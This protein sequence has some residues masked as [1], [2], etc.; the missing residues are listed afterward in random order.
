MDG[1]AP[2]IGG[3]RRCW[4]LP[5]GLLA[6]TTVYCVT[7]ALNLTPYVRGPREWRWVYA[8]PEP[9][10]WLWIPSVTLLFYIGLAKLWVRSSGS[11]KGKRPLKRRLLLGA[12]ILSV[13]LL[14]LSLLAGIYGDPLKPLF[15]RTVSVGASGVFSVG[16]TI[17]DAGEFLRRY[18]DLMPTFPV[19]PQRYPPGLPLLFYGLRRLFERLPGVANVVGFWLRPYQ[20]HDLVLMRLPNTTL[21]TAL[22]Q[23]A[24]PFF[25]GLTLLPLYAFARQVMGERTAVFVA[26]LY[27]LVPS[28]ALWSARWEQFYPLLTVLVGYAFY[29][30][31]VKPSRSVMFL[32][33]LLLA[34]SSFLNF[35][36]LT[37][38]ILCGL[39]ALTYA[40][41]C[42]ERQLRRHM[43]LDAMVFFLGLALPWI[44]YQ[45]IFGAGFFD[46]WRV[47]MSYHLGLERSYWTWV[48]FHLY[49]FFVFLGLPL[50]VLFLVGM[51]RAVR[52]LWG[53]FCQRGVV[54]TG[55]MM[56]VAVSGGILLLDLS[57]VSRGEV[58]RVWLFLTPL[59]AL[60]A[61]WGLATIPLG[62]SEWGLVFV[63]VLLA[64]QLSIGNAYLRV[65]TTGLSDPPSY[66]SSAELPEGF[67][68]IGARFGNKGPESGDDGLAVLLGYYL[69][70]SE[71]HPG[72]SL[73]LTLYWQPQRRFARA[74]TVATH[75]V[76]SKGNLISQQ[77]HMPLN[78]ELPTTCWIPGIT[79]ADPSFTIPIPA[80]VPAGQYAILVGMY[81]LDTGERLPVEGEAATPHNLALLAQLTIGGE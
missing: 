54:D 4:L 75:L 35:S 13:P 33:G 56:A 22:L 45:A 7:L 34:C 61:A 52:V 26:A 73:R 11:A 70:P 23:M 55:A 24:L 6:V 62:H 2:N 74:Y 28:F 39:F 69:E 63:V 36:L 79:V 9:A 43:V 12:L 50:A 53:N 76:D 40:T 10:H 71:P 16:S 3:L 20:C 38:L 37:L 1:Q 25:S 57:G 46:I 5:L 80:S 78:G 51:V 64:L 27:P 41:R 14:Q 59:A 66:V 19:H 81:L 31:L 32:A 72:D 65:V 30:G 49:D 48:G 42:S 68:P 18:P 67:R 21:A 29:I 60:V 58:A 8:R 44:F 77:D 17:E 47:S 15:Y